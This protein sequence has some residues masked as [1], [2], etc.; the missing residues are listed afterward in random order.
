MVNK[1]AKLYGDTIVIDSPTQSSHVL[2]RFPELSYAFP[3]LSQLAAVQDE[4]T[5]VLRE[6]QF[7]YRANYVRYV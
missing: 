2:E 4:L 3:T 6:Q 7:G 5:A 1:L